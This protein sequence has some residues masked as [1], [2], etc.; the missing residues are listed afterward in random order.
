[1]RK[2]LQVKQI[3]GKSKGLLV[4]RLMPEADWRGSCFGLIA[5]EM[6]ELCN[7]NSP[8]D[9]RQYCTS[10]FII[11]SILMARIARVI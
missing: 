9:I 2:P 8:S 7:A 6:D 10:M 3:E 1:M 5:S 4:P 11:V